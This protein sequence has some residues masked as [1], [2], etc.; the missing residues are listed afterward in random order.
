MLKLMQTE[1]TLGEKL[2]ILSDA[3]KYDVHAHLAAQS[4]R[5]TEKEWETAGKQEFVI[6]FRQTGGVFL[7]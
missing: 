4:A 7:F 6:V 1:M 5:E 2:E 3:A